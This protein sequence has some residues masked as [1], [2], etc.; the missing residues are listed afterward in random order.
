MKTVPAKP[1]AGLMIVLFVVTIIGGW[2]YVDNVRHELESKIEALAV[3]QAPASQGGGGRI[4][5]PTV[6]NGW[7]LVT[8]AKYAYALS[9]PPG[10]HF[11]EDSQNDGLAYVL[12]DPNSDDDN[13]LPVMTVNVTSAAVK[14]THPG[15]MIQVGSKAYWFSLWE[16]MEWGPY[17]QVIASFRV[18]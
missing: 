13:P 18:E 5:A 3:R 11:L 17:D 12:P 4:M 7:H 2:L 14:E 16:D 10:Y 8:S 6:A 15:K 1:I 9:L